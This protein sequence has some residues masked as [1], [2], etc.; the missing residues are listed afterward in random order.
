QVGKPGGQQHDHQCQQHE[1]LGRVRAGHLVEQARQ[2]P[3][4]GQQQADEQD[5]GLAQGQRQRPV[6][7]LAALAGEHR[8]QGQ[9]QYRNHV[10]EQQHANG[11]LAVAAEDFAEAGEL[12]ADDGGGRQRQ[13]AAQQQGSPGRHAKQPQQAGQQQRRADHLQAAQAEDH[14]AQGEHLAQGE[15]KAQGK[16]QEHHAH[17]GEVGQFFAFID[18]V[19]GG[20]ADEQADAQ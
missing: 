11:V 17:F 20:G 10:L 2:Q 14:A 16:Q 12:L 6:P 18:P 9:Q 8:H 7:G 13:A 5:H 19:Q 15:F 3:A 1:Q 4:V